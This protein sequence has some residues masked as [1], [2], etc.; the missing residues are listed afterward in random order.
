MAGLGS[1][2]RRDLRGGGPNLG[3]VGRSRPRVQ[4]FKQPVVAL[5]LLHLRDAR[6]RIVEI[7]KDD[8]VGRAGR[9]AGGD[10][11]T[12]LDAA[13]LAL[14]VDARVV[15]AL[16]A[17]GA[18]FHHAAA[19]DGHVRVAQ[20]LEARRLPILIEEEV[21]APH[22]VWAVVRAVARADAAVVDHVVQAFRAMRRRA[23]GADQL[24]RRGLALHAGDRLVIR[25]DRIG[26]L[27]V[28][29]EVVVDADPVHLAPAIHLLLADDRDVV[30]G[31][32][33]DGAGAAARARRQVDRHAP[34]VAVVFPLGNQRQRA[35]RR[36]AHVRDDFGIF[37]VFLGGGDA[38]RAA[39]LHQV[40][41]LRARE[42][43]AAN[44][45][46]LEPAAEVGRVRRAQAEHVELFRVVRRRLADVSRYLAAVAVEHRD[47]VVGMS[48]ND[49]DRQLGEVAAIAQLDQVSVLEPLLLG[50]RHAHPRARVPRDLR[51]RLGQLLQPAV[52]REAAIPDGRVGAEN[53]LETRPSLVTGNWRLVTT[54]NWRLVTTG[55]WRLVTTGY[56]QLATD[57]CRCGLDSGRS[58]HV[59]IVQHV[60]PHAVCALELGAR[61]IGDLP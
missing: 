11:F 35:R 46:D 1:G 26:V 38:D 8:R 9:G 40:V 2:S 43:V 49:R 25:L 51:D 12:V 15:D 23:D 17:V 6:F 31:L 58:R 20:R 36:L 27:R 24:A 39:P 54:G 32:A 7:A 42:Q 60:L 59:P 52:V 29:L 34:L 61:R 56:W 16:D 21:E 14:G 10:H 30:L 47:R 41:F 53:D 3:Q 50:S 13:V 4:I 57:R 48:R 45:G 37:L 22:L 55:N 5:E 19:A 44:L 28:T 33:R 18:L